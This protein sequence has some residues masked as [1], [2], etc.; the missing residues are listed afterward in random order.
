MSIFAYVYM[1]LSPNALDCFAYDVIYNETN[2][3]CID[4]DFRTEFYPLTK[5]LPYSLKGRNM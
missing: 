5:E 3:T 4:Q 1:P 2:L